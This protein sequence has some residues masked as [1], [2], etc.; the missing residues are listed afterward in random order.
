VIVDATTRAIRIVAAH[1][2]ARIVTPAWTPDGAAI[3]AAVDY[4]EQPFDLFEFALDGSTP[5]GR[6]LTY[7]S[8]G[9]TWPDVSPDGTSIVFVG[10][11]A[12][13]FDLFTTPYRQT[14]AARSEF[15]IAPGSGPVS[16]PTDRAGRAEARSRSESSGGGPA[17]TGPDRCKGGCPAYSPWPTLMPTSWTPIVER[18]DEALRLGIGVGGYDVLGRHGYS[19]SA[20]WL[21]NRPDTA[22]LPHA[23]SPDWQIQYLYDRWVPTFFVAA[24]Q[25]TSFGAGPPD[26]AGRPTSAT[27]RE[28]ELTAGVLYPIRRVRVSH[29]ALASLVQSTDRFTFAD[30]LA[31]HDTA[32]ARFGWTTSTARTYGYSISREDG[33]SFGGTAEF[34]GDRFGSAAVRTVTTDGR[35]Y[36]RGAAAHHVLALRAAVGVS[37][38]DADRRRTFHLGGS[39][40]NA[41]VL[42]FGR[43]AI[44]LLRGFGARTFAGSHV[45]LMN[46]E[47][48]WPITRPQRGVGTIPLLLHSVHAAAF[49]DAGHAWTRAFS[50]R[51]AKIAAGGELSFDFIALY[52]A[53]LTL[54]IGAAWGHDRA[55]T[56]PGGTVYARLG[57]AF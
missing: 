51:D 27:L 30:R 15:P 56:A 34:E 23:A 43:D 33:W 5:K 48:R 32:G 52:S 7:T 21:V 42:D 47:Y 6:R 31:S 17:E 16:A 26:V 28:H 11:T 45:A 12:D 29:R 53:P 37:S 55:G 10:Y 9:A 49:A 35:A 46:S 18:G 40:A 20:T 57:R 24:S 38:G 54:A 36:L 1:P 8:G 14:R 39:S 19:A 13:G 3:I 22:P 25:H 4:D 41:E 44:S 50:V 2:S